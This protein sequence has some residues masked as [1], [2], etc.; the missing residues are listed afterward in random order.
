V[1]RSS[2]IEVHPVIEGDD[3]YRSSE[4]CGTCHRAT[5]AEWKLSPD[6][7]GKQKE[8]CQGCHMPEVRRKVESVNDQHAYSRA[9]VAL[10][11]GED[12]RRHAFAVPDDADEDLGLT[13]R[14]DAS[15]H[16]LVTFVTNRL[17]HR[18]PTGQFGRRQL[19]LEVRWSGGEQRVPLVA[20]AAQTLAP[21]E[22][23][24]VTFALPAGALGAALHLSLL[25]YDHALAGWSEIAG[26]DL[27]PGPG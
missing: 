25:R 4:L 8:T 14:L 15:S 5:L 17:P 1:S 3:S 10:E 20:A 23:R 27:P 22:T 2:P 21:G 9:L 11:R 18:L 16:T 24:S 6:P 7:A 13:A 12:L 19:A 26:A